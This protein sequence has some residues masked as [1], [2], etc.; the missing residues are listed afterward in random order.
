MAFVKIKTILENYMA[1]S[2]KVELRCVIDS[3]IPC[4]VIANICIN[5]GTEKTGTRR[6][7]TALFVADEN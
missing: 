5:L 7:M 1:L 6:F 2:T 3:A 4:L